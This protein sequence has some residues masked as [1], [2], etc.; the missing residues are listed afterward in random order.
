MV[1]PASIVSGNW[2]L[3]NARAVEI[4]VEAALRLADE[5]KV[6]VVHDDM[7]VGARS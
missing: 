5:A 3:S 4:H 2:M 6:G 1:A 7:D